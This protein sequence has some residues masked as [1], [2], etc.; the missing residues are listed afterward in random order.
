MDG[1]A[2]SWAWPVGMLAGG[3]LVGAVLL[4]L[5]RRQAPA[6][7]ATDP[8]ELRDLDGQLEVLLRQLREIDDLATEDPARAASERFALEVQAAQALRAREQG[9]PAAPVA[10]PAKAA[11]AAAPTDFLATRPALR[12]F[13]WGT[14]SA[15]AVAVLVFFVWRQA[16][17]R[18][19]GGSLTGNLPG[20]E[21]RR[22]AA[23]GDPR[24]PLQQRIARNP[25]DLEARLDLAQLHLR[26]R[27]LMGVW[28][29]TQYVLEKQPGQPRALAYQALVRLAMG[30]PQVA[31]DMLKQAL[32]AD[33]DL[34]EGYLHLA[35]VQVRMGLATDA[36]ATIKIASARFPT[37]APML[38]KVLDEMRAVGAET[39]AAE[40]DPHA[41][42]AAPAAGA[43]APAA[44]HLRGVIELPDAL[45]AKVGSQ[46]LLFVTVRPAGVAQG[47]PVAVK[48]MPAASFPLEFEIGPADSMMGQ[49][50]PERARVEA[51]VD[52]DGNPLTRDPGDPS[53]RLDDV[54][55]GTRLRLVLQ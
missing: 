9:T 32:A 28:N 17:P 6:A 36:E 20:E 52:S 26:Q 19:E 3:L 49:P 48:R 2:V 29:E 42:V 24:A 18:E 44:V 40:G 1:A 22:A 46:A 13:L 15:A 45:R 43:P 8:V 37:Q 23:A 14:G 47:P 53:A 11:P 27:D 51:R 41:A 55:A 25:D 30:Q 39:P 34:L 21:E 4:F 38:A 54:A 10:R 50:L 16:K 33:P 31:L 35:L 7:L 5:V 12:G